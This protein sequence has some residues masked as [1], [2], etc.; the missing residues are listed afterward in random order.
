[1]GDTV[2]LIP[3]Y[4]ERDNLSKL[5]PK[6][7]EEYPD[8]HILV[9]DD[10]SPDGTPNLLKELSSKYKNLRYVVRVG[11]RGLG[12]ALLR[13]YREALKHGYR[14][15]IQMDADLQHDPK[16]IKDILERLIDGCDLVIASRYVAGGGVEG[17]SLLRRI[18]SKAANMYS[19]A[20]LGIK[21]RDA[22]SGYRGFKLDSLGRII[23]DI[24]YSRGYVIQVETV[25][26]FSQAG[27]RICEVPFIFR[28]RERGSSKLGITT[29]L[30]FFIKV[31]RLK[32]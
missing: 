10:N 12:T 25:Y 7:F 26:R 8:I 4:N 24:K 13:G 32:L 3:T 30:E 2:V 22:T 20:I 31:I 9:I 18:V 28:E 16:Y 19:R 5:I 14:Y 1:M 29:I 6:I 27:M 23:D 15:L 17:W 21:V 11:E